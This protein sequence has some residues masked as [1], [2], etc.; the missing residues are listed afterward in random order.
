VIPNAP[1][2]AEAKLYPAVQGFL[3]G[4]RDH[5]YEEGRDYVMETRSIQG[6]SA[7]FPEA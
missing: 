4:M 7:R 1:T 2:W 6:N 5:G 3:A